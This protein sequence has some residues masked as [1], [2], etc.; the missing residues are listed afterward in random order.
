MFIGGRGQRG[1]AGAQL[2]SL[3]VGVGLGQQMPRVAVADFVTI[4]FALRDFRNKQ[5]PY[6]AGAVRAHRVHP[7]IPAIE[8][9]HHADA[10]GVRRPDGEAHPFDAVD[11]DAVRTQHPVALAQLAFAEQVQILPGEMRRELVGVVDFMGR[12]AVVHAQ[13]IGAGGFAA[14]APFEYPGGV[15]LSEP[16]G[17]VSGQQVN[18]CGV[19]FMHPDN[20]LRRRAVQAEKSKWIMEAGLQQ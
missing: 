2:I 9:S 7:A 10:F 14:A 18:A 3:R 11:L 17:A 19:R 20:P 8:F 16:V 15:N 1:R 5:L 4:Q 12:A 6:S 13:A